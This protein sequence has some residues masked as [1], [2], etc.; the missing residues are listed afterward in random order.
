M[1]ARAVTVWVVASLLVVGCSAQ[2]PVASS[3]PAAAA[4]PSAA[5]ALHPRPTLTS[6]SL[7]T[8]TGVGPV[9]VGMTLAEGVA[10]RIVAPGAPEPCAD[11]R[12]DAF[13]RAFPGVATEWT[14]DGLRTVLIGSKDYATAAG[15]RVGDSL[16]D[17]RRA[18][19]DRLRLVP[20]DLEHFENLGGRGG[21]LSARFGA[22]IP[23][24]AG[25]DGVLLF[26][27]FEGRVDHLE[28]VPAG[29]DRLLTYAGECR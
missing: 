21:P 16:A 6:A 2:A 23:T 8:A 10:A 29:E 19:G 12:T 15:V 5:E 13:L 3:P 9:R 27:L 18:Y 25:A 22:A 4:A 26:P 20:R 24:V 1:T 17:L 11:L 28:V 7:V 14:P